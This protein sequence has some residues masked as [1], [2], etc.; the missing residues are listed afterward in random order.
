MECCEIDSDYPH[1]ETETYWERRA[2]KST[3]KREDPNGRR[4]EKY[5]CE[6]A[7]CSNESYANVWMR[8]IV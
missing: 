4:A 1:I 5:I 8:K 6:H 3:E 7:R 2:E